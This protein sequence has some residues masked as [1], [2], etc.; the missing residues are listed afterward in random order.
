MQQSH[1]GIPQEPAYLVVITGVECSEIELMEWDSIPQSQVGRSGGLEPWDGVV[2]GSC[3]HLQSQPPVS[4]HGTESTQ[5][6]N[7]RTFSLGF[8]IVTVLPLT[9]FFSVLPP[10]Q[11]S[12]LT[13]VLISQGLPS[14]NQISGSSVW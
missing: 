2:V 10:N 4:S 12:C 13:L 7:N 14:C 3:P 8:Q 11:I 1:H 9:L 6:P 5:L